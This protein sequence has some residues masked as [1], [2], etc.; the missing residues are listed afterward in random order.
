MCLSQNTTG[1]LLLARTPQRAK[2]LS[3]DFRQHK[4]YKKYHALVLNANKPLAVGDTGSV[5]AWHWLDRE[6]RPHL[7][8]SEA[9]GAREA[10]TDWRVL[11]LS[12]RLTFHSHHPLLT[13]F[14]CSGIQTDSAP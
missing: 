2:E 8:S 5:T 12:V 11:A 3:R 7:T 6:N 4:I 13:A 10:R 1:A 9:D 14:M